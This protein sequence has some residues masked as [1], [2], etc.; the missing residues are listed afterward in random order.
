M[1]QLGGEGSL[2]P[3]QTFYKL[4]DATRQITSFVVGVVRASRCAT[5]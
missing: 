2:M 1:R 3:T 4:D 5:P